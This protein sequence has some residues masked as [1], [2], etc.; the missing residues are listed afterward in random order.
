VTHRID[1]FSDDEYWRPSFELA[2]I[3]DDVLIVL[4]VR[5]QPL[6]TVVYAL[7]P[8][9]QSRMKFGDSGTRGAC[10]DDSQ[11]IGQ[12]G[13]R[14]REDVKELSCVLWGDDHMTFDA[15]ISVVISTLKPQDTTG[16]M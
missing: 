4:V 6:E 15:E 11:E 2:V 3:Y 8:D 1:Q 10:P 5:T 14:E 12:P 9:R 7:G 13:S 16:C